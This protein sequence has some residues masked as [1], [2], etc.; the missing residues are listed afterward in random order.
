[1]YCS[2][3]A[4]CDTCKELK[5]IP[6]LKHVGNVILKILISMQTICEDKINEAT[7]F[8]VIAISLCKRKLILTST[9]QS[10]WRNTLCTWLVQRYLMQLCRQT[11]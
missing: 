9:T 7:L 2:Y 6:I 4:V 10:I 1:M 11:I 3:D 5:W 8:V